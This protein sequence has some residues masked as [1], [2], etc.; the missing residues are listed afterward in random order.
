LSPFVLEL[1]LLSVLF[2]PPPLL[3]P[4]TAAQ[5]PRAADFALV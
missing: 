2:A 1:A 5:L 4:C 3:L